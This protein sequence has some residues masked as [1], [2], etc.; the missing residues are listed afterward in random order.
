MEK[1]DNFLNNFFD[2]FSRYSWKRHA[3][4]NSMER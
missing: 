2:Y 3:D 4:K 1:R